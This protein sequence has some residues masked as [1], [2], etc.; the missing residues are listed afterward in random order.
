MCK[1]KKDTNEWFQIWDKTGT[2]NIGVDDI[3][4]PDKESYDNDNFESLN[5]E[6]EDSD[7]ARRARRRYPEWKPKRDLKDKVELIVGLNFS[8]PA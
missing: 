3:N 5:S 4:N 2:S 8:N 7:G 1:A 6:Q